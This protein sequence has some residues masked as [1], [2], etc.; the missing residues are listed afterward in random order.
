MLGITMILGVSAGLDVYYLPS[1]ENIIKNKKKDTKKSWRD[2]TDTHEQ[3]T[4]QL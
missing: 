4:G 1:Y 2:P 3:K